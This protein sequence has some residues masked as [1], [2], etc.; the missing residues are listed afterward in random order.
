MDEFKSTGHSA[1]H[2]MAC[3]DKIEELQSYI[4]KV[5]DGMS[6][7]FRGNEELQELQDQMQ[8]GQV[9]VGASDEYTSHH[10]LGGY[11]IFQVTYEYIDLDDNYSDTSVVHYH[12]E[13]VDLYLQ[14]K[15]TELLELVIAQQQ[16]LADKA[17]LGSIEDLKRMA[18][19]M[20]YEIKEKKNG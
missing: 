13:W 16:D 15:H 3:S 12:F 6:D 10:R 19:L 11:D 2:L 18:D 7:L 14:G 1:I 5:F 9:V 20:G 17:T 8:S 4:A